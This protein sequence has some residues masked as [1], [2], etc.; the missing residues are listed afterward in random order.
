MKEASQVTALVYDHGLF[1][2]L[3]RHLAKT[4]KRVLYFTPWETAFPTLN[5]CII[6]DGYPDVERCN[7]IWSVKKEID[8]WCFPD[9][10]HSGLQLELESQGF[11]VWGSRSGDALEIN[12][13]K[14]NRVLKEVGLKVPDCEEIIGLDALGE[15]LKD[16][17][18]RFIK[19]SKYR[20]SFETFKWRSWE[21]D[22]NIL[23][24]WAV[25]FGPASAYMRFLVFTPIET[26][27]EI[28]GDTYDVDGQWPSLMLHGEEQ[29]DKGYLGAVTAREAMPQQL[30]DVMEAFSPVLKKERYRNQWSM[31]MRD[32]NFIDACCRGGL[33]STGAQMEAWTNLPEIIYAGAHGELVEPE[34]DCDFVAECV[35][36]MK[37]EKT[38]WG[39]TVMPKGLEDNVK[40]GGCCRIDGADCFPPD[41]SHGEEIGWLVTKGSTIEE[42]VEEMKAKAKLLPDGVTAHTDSLIDLLQGIKEA[43]KEGIVFTDDRIPP[44][45][46]VLENK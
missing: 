40:L 6:G 19:M 11:P 9:I 21:L 22:A 28:G 46:I 20:G 39:K 44:P 35:L 45:E 23:D 7:D 36:T 29:K 3:A 13:Q 26:T 31:E 30:Q 27:L 37:S 8:L 1:L 18:E 2:P 38:M 43:E 15:H 34:T 32:D 17:D 25:K 14:F 16:A 33:P 42:V 12:R 41:D 4:Y 5:Q 24:F 10:Q